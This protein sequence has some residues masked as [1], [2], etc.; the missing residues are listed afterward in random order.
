MVQD[1][2]NVNSYFTHLKSYWDEIQ[3]FYPMPKCTYGAV[4]TVLDYKQCEYVLQFLIGLNESFASV[5]GQ[6]LLMDPIPHIN[7]VF[8]LVLQEEC[9]CPISISTSIP[10]TVVMFS[11][12][13]SNKSFS[14]NGSS[15]HIRGKDRSICQH[16]GKEGHTIDKCYRLHGFPPGF[17]F[18]RNKSSIAN[19]VSFPGT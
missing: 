12:S 10:K 9:Q 19:N 3:N 7:K 17:K 11:K 2:E 14:R 18:T 13:G 8:S 1:Q 5:H 16:C 4:Q 6:I 15:G